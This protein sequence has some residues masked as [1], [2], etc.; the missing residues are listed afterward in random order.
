MDLDGRLT[1]HVIL[2]TSRRKRIL[3]PENDGWL[4]MVLRIACEACRCFCLAVGGHD[5]HVHVVVEMH[6]GASLAGL[7]RTMKS[8]TCREWT[9]CGGTPALRWQKRYWARTVDSHALGWLVPYVTEQR[10]RH[11]GCAVR[12]QW[13]H[14]PEIFLA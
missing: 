6:P 3:E 10:V 9:E 5:D 1:L 8:F 7:V 14:A 4:S 2:T 13:E 12:P 11:A